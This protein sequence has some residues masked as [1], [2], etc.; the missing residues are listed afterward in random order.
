LWNAVKQAYAIEQAYE[1]LQDVDLK[2][3][4]IEYREGSIPGKLLRIGTIN[5]LVFN[6]V[7]FFYFQRQRVIRID[8]ERMKP[9]LK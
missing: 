5:D 4:D 2:D 3:V 6:N 7:M 1:Y 8:L 9:C